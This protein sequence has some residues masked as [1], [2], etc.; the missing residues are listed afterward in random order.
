M[1]EPYLPLRP[2]LCCNP[3]DLWFNLLFILSSRFLCYALLL[4]APFFSTLNPL[5]LLLSEMAPQRLTASVC[6]LPTV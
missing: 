2:S 5:V 1:C 4:T 3:P 6:M